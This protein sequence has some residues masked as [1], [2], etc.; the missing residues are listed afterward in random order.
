MIDDD[1]SGDLDYMELGKEIKKAG[2]HPP[3]PAPID[4]SAK[5]VEEITKGP[6]KSAAKKKY[7]NKEIKDIKELDRIKAKARLEKEKLSPTKKS[8]TKGSKNSKDS[9]S[10]AGPP[11]LPS[12]E[13]FVAW[14]S[15]RL[16]SHINLRAYMETHHVKIPIPSSK[17]KTNGKTV[18]H[19]ICSNKSLKLNLLTTFFKPP[20]TNAHSEQATLCD[21][22]G[23]TPLHLLAQNT[24]SNLEMIQLILSKNRNAI[25][26]VD[27]FGKTP[28]M[29]A[30]ERSCMTP[31]PET[32]S[33]VDYL[34]KI[35]C[36]P[37]TVVNIDGDSEERSISD[38]P[39]RPG[40]MR[41]NP[42][43]SLLWA[44]SRTSITSA[45][46][47]YLSN[48]IIAE[49]A[50]LLREKNAHGVTS[51]VMAE[52]S[53]S[54]DVQK[55]F[56]AKAREYSVENNKAYDPLKEKSGSPKKNGGSPK[57]RKLNRWSSVPDFNLM[58]PI[59][60]M[61]CRVFHLLYVTCDEK[62][63]RSID[64]FLDFDVDDSGTVDRKEFS[65]GVKNLGIHLSKAQ[66]KAVFS[67]VDKD[68]SG[69]LEYMEISKEIKK[70]GR[71]PPPPAPPL[72]DE[73]LKALMS[74]KKKKKKKVKKK[75]IELTQEQKVWNKVYNLME[76][77]RV[78]PVKLFHDI[79]E[80][81]S[82]IIT[83]S[84]LRIGF[85]Q[86]LNIE[87]GDDEFKACLKI[88]DRDG[89]FYIQKKK[90]VFQQKKKSNIF[91]LPFYLISFLIRFK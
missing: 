86:L 87:L 3:P 36:A 38:R 8:P 62:K 28:L 11:K 60:L 16:I 47:L 54:Q 74:P 56:R 91:F 22:T 70:A 17:S 10:V 35:A 13:R 67:V 61:A 45:C 64:V 57:K 37:M 49:N 15:S 7:G 63:M 29:Y 39:E 4:P 42:L 9:K 2:K 55:L 84:E 88:C 48:R 53:F 43:H 66:K 12:I 31:Q 24:N 76:K 79:D 89:K 30:Y 6:M 40:P 25:H 50:L 71:Y 80:D 18:L 26:L 33:V 58:D 72:T 85:K 34:I 75:K 5:A 73:E 21:D 78:K 46:V 19:G 41:N 77:Q 27:Q 69:E 51:L 44:F 81:E 32:V 68:N 1:G 82:G 59:K 65:K 14:S 52:S 23:S 20:H 90:N 83:A